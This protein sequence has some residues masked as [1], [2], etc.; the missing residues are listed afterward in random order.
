MK[1][2]ILYEVKYK[3]LW[4]YTVDGETKEAAIASLKLMIP[5][6]IEV[7]RVDAV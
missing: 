2:K 1:W 4:E 7:I 3:G 5:D 6:E